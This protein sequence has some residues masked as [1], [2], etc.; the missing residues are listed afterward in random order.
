MKVKHMFKNLNENLV[1]TMLLFNLNSTNGEV[2]FNNDLPQSGHLI[3]E[4]PCRE[5]DI[6][7]N[8]SEI[9]KELFKEESTYHLGLIFEISL[10]LWIKKKTNVN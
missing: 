6:H 5:M 4:Q 8:I 7:K 2:L 9:V 10:F 3:E 1:L